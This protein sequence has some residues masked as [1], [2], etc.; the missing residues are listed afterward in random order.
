[1]HASHPGRGADGHHVPVA[2]DARERG[3][4]R[5]ER[6]ALKVT[7]V[8]GRGLAFPHA[9]QAIQILRRCRLLT[10]KHSKK[11]STETVYAVTSLTA[12][13]AQPAELAQIVR[14]HRE[15]R[16]A[17]S[18]SATSP[19]TRTDPR[20]APAT[21]LAS[22]L[23]YLAIAILR[24]AGHASIAAAVRYRARRPSRLLQTIMK[25]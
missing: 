22:W 19:T 6:H 4:G 23:A 24:L 1:V 21:D 7:A 5:A 2:Y 25:C 12:F 9:A 20:S 15:S 13:Q 3:H 17:C 18:E 10:G 14:G 11:W 16:T 8:A